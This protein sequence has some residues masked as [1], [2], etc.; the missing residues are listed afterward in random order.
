MPSTGPPEALRSSPQKDKSKA[1]FQ[2]EIEDTGQTEDAIRL[3]AGP[4]GLPLVLLFARGEAKNEAK[5]KPKRSHL[6]PPRQASHL[7]E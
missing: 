2:Y 1:N 5:T 4:R 7:I 3:P 6:L